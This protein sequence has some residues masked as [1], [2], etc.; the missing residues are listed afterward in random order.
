MKGLDLIN[1]FNVSAASH[2]VSPPTLLCFILLSF[3]L[4]SLLSSESSFQ[5]NL[6]IVGQQEV[7]SGLYSWFKIPD[8]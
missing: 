8:V 3:L 5:S 6:D 4:I 2:T 7:A 1:R